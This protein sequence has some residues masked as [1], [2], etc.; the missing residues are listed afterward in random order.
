MD[1]DKLERAYSAW[2]A[3]CGW[4]QNLEDW[5]GDVWNWMYN[6]EIRLQQTEADMKAIKT[7]NHNLTQ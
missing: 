6:L 4:L 3:H 5:L 1:V 2:R 7:R